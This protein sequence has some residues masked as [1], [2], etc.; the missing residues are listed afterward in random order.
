MPGIPDVLLY[1]SSIITNEYIVQVVRIWLLKLNFTGIVVKKA[2]RLL[3]TATVGG[4]G[5]PTMPTKNVVAIT[6]L[7]F[8]A[9]HTLL[10]SMSTSSTPSVLFFEPFLPRSLVTLTSLLMGILVRF[11]QLSYNEWTAKYV[12]GFVLANRLA[13]SMHMACRQTLIASF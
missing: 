2:M 9:S 12:S 11:Q 13:T 5:A 4:I 1:P 3:R 6:T 8:M 7:H 10:D